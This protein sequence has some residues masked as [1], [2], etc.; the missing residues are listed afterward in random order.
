MLVVRIILNKDEAI[1]SYLSQTTKSLINKEQL[2]LR[3]L[4][5]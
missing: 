4:P 3:N 5:N 1:V 2:C